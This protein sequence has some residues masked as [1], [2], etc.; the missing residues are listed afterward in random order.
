MDHV[1]HP[2][3]IAPGPGPAPTSRN[4]EEILDQIVRIQR[5]YFRDG[6]PQRMWD[7]L[8]DSILDTS[9]SAYGFIAEVVWGRSAI[10][11]LETRAMRWTEAHHAPVT[12]HPD[13]GLVVSQVIASE[14]PLIIPPRSVSH[15]ASRFSPASG[16]LGLPLRSADR[17]VAVVG[18][19]GPESTYDEAL[20][21]FLEPLL[22]ASASIVESIQAARARDAAVG[23]L[24]QTAGFLDAVIE[25]TAHGILVVSGEEG[26]IESANRAAHLILDPPAETVVGR[27]LS[28]IVRPADRPIAERILRVARRR[29]LPDRYRTFEVVLPR[30]DGGLFPAEAT[31]SDFSIGGVGRLVVLFR[32]ISDRVHAEQTSRR[33]ME[34]IDAAPDLIAWSDQTGRLM[35]VNPGGRTLLGLGDAVGGRR[36]VELCAP[37]SEARL[38]DQ[39]IPQAL[40]EGSWTGELTLLDADDGEV[41]VWMVVIAGA[42][43]EY[44]AFLARD[45][46]ERQQVE[47]IKD[48]FISNVSHELRTPLTSIMGFVELMMEGAFGELSPDMVSALDV[49][50][51]NGERLLDLIGQILRVSLLTEDGAEF[52]EQVDLSDVIHSAVGALA[53]V[54]GSHVTS[55]DVADGIAVLGDRNELLTVATNLL[56]NAYKFT[57]EPGSVSVSLRQFGDWVTLEVADSGIGIPERE[58]DLIFERFQRGEGARSREIQGTGLGLALVQAIVRRHRG[59]ISV[60]SQVGVGSSF[61]VMFPVHTGKE[62]IPNGTSTGRGR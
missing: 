21:T 55:I 62:V 9:G 12:A 60:N 31:L 18:L 54:R 11:E 38:V 37:W 30:G 16:F 20:V 1:S 5:E 56:A 42:G 50:E 17:L 19:T 52:T 2:D 43:S 14:A 34:I 59:R 49:V 53:G 6:D 26:R 51:R 47:R 7:L 10:P 35:Y 13:V 8:I 24:E 57:P 15:A 4:R 40:L 23:R 39:A 3:P 45:L 28:D 48:A 46:R 27:R 58:I 61:R 36:V 33:A 29:G 44:L 32:D 22:A 25:S 41:P